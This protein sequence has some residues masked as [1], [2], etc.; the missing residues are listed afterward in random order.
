MQK[1]KLILSLLIFLLAACQSN[2]AADAIPNISQTKDGVTV[3]I[4]NIDFS[5]IDTIVTFV[6]Q[7]DADWGLEVTA[8]PFP[9]A[10]YNNPVLFN[11][12][13]QQHA[14]IAGTYGLPQSDEA[15]GGVK[16]ENV[17]TFPPME[18]QRVEFQTE[19]EISEIP[20]SQ[21]VSVSIANHQL[22][23][24]WS[25]GSGITFS[26]FTNVPG[27]VKLVSQSGDTLVL[28]FMFDRVTNGDLRLG[29]L[30]F[31]PAN[32]DWANN[33]GTEN[34]FRECLADEKEI[35]SKTGMALPTDQKL[36]IPFHVTGS[37]IFVDPF[38][39]AW[40]TTQK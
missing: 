22:L 23:D 15:T 8:D 10:L 12:A 33:E 2:T 37:A 5:E 26:K 6:V 25:I 9:Q 28:E 24:V 39:M 36:P 34:H 1:Q 32:Q 11:E 31:Y 13:G 14:A 21:P 19:I 16:F 38:R 7:V 18:S 30:N 20:I 17:V 27:T 4:T 35:I 29:C 3:T 40:S